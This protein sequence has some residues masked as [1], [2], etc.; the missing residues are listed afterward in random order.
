MIGC[1][2]HCGIQR[3]TIVLPDALYTR[4]KEAKGSELNTEKERLLTK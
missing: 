3:L 1:S 2:I 4:R